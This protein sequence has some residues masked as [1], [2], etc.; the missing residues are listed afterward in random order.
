MMSKPKTL[1]LA[2]LLGAL[3]VLPAFAD[4]GGPGSS[5]FGD[6]ALTDPRLLSRYL[7]LSAAQKTQLQGFLRT[8]QT[9]IQG[10]RTAQ[11]PLCQTLRTDVAAANPNPTT[12]GNDY[13]A[14]IDNQD[15]VKVALTAFDTSFSGILTA[16]QLTRYDHLKQIVGLG[17]GQKSADLLPTCPPAP[18][19]H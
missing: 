2:L 17:D 18:A 9:A 4:R 6:G 14:L 3:C 15:K 19:T 16:D 11:G 13:L 1:V 10:V 8:L 5:G 12:V 7:N